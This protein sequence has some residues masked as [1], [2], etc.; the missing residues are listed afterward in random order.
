LGHGKRRG[1]LS[2]LTFA[3]WADDGS[4]LLN[5]GKAYSG[6][7]DAEIADMTGRLRSLAVADDGR[8]YVVR[9]EIVVEI[10]F[11]QIQKSARHD[12]GYAL[13]FPRIKTIRNDKPPSEADTLARV[14]E[15]YGSDANTAREVETDAEPNEPTLFD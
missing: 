15:I 1:V 9:P 13:R 5:I 11:D 6:L 12:S 14:R 7:T 8:R 2:D 3:V 10:A 4:T